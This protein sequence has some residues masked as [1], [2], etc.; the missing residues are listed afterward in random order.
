MNKAIAIEKMKRARDKIHKG[1][2]QYWYA[3][4]IEGNFT[5]AKSSTACSWCSMGAIK[6]VTDCCEEIHYLTELFDMCS[7]AIWNYHPT[8][9]RQ[10]VIDKFDE[11]ITNLEKNEQ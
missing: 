2:T 5:G 8:R 4:D 7:I 10:E 6:S 9:T 3:K 1:W 11:V